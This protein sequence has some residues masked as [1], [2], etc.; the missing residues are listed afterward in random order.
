MK[1][2]LIARAAGLSILFAIASNDYGMSGPYTRAFRGYHD[3]RA[4]DALH[5]FGRT[6][7]YPRYDGLERSLRD[8][9]YPGTIDDN[10]GPRLLD[11]V[12]I[13]TNSP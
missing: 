11:L 12:R 1:I 5:H 4:Q 6:D 3:M 13:F 9:N 8:G 7:V 10:I 2:S